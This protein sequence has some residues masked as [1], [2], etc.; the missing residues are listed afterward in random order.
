M[1]TLSCW[2]IGSLVLFFGLPF[3]SLKME[4]LDGLGFILLLFFVINPLFFAIFGV[5]SGLKTKKRW[6]LPLIAVI[7]NL[8]GVWVT[9]DFGNLDFL[10]YCE[11]YIVISYVAMAITTIIKRKRKQ[12]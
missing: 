9:L 3:I 12:K 4:S 5:Y 11:Y 1:K 8:L 10:V 7:F 6:Y 2:F